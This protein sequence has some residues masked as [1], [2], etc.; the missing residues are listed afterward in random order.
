[1]PET[2]FL[3]PF[4]HFSLGAALRLPKTYLSQIETI[5]I[6]VIVIALLLGLRHA[7]LAKRALKLQQQLQQFNENNDDEPGQVHLV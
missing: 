6:I 5:I 2:T 1:M 4:A 7:R 3:N